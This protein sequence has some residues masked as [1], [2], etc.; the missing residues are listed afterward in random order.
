MRSIKYLIMIIFALLMINACNDDGGGGNGDVDNTIDSSYDLRLSIPNLE[1]G[2]LISHGGQ[3][4]IRAY[5]LKTTTDSNGNK[6]EVPVEDGTVIHFFVIATD[7][8]DQKNS[9]NNSGTIESVKTTLDGYADAVYQ[10]ENNSGNV[11]IYAATD[12]NMVY[13]ISDVYEENILTDT[14]SFE[15][16]SGTP[17][18]IFIDSITPETIGVAGS[19]ISNISIINF[20][21]NDSSGNPVPD[22][23]LVTFKISTAIGGGE[24]LSTTEAET[25][26]G[27]V[28][29][30]LTSGTVSGT[31]GI[32]AIYNDGNTDLL[33]EA[34][35][36]IVS[37]LPAA[38]QLGMAVEYHNMAGGRTFGL[39][40]K[41]TAYLGDRYGNVVP[42]GT[43]V[44]FM[45]EGGTIGTSDGFEP[46]TVF[47]VAEAV[48]QTSPPTTPDLG[49]VNGSTQSNPGLCRIVIYTPGNEG[50]YDINGNNVYDEGI[51]T[52]TVDMSEPYIDANDNNQYDSGEKYIDS[53]GSGSFTQADG[54]YQSNTIIWD[55]G[56]VLFSDDQAALDLTKNF[57]INRINGGSYPLTYYLGDVYG[58]ALVSGTTVKITTSGAF[59]KAEL[60]GDTDFVLP[61]SNGFGEWHTVGLLI[62]PQGTDDPDNGSLEVIVTVTPPSD[63]SAGENSSGPVTDTTGPL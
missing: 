57:N 56:N 13:N 38:E 51:D 24:K 20:S 59:G 36:T 63:D 22:Y 17:A 37:G 3:T 50:F 5:V 33:T 7:G 58:N 10:A 23:N 45:S 32:N 53:D 1:P 46:S 29:V 14:I 49:G 26:N 31:V 2:S 41:I 18:T 52:L 19:G 48:L 39:Q 8:I 55:S 27:K 25:Q 60:T 40:N 30:S 34:K 54:K 61:D 21:V 11:K 62:T 9:V 6:T 4:T 43:K 16:A 15:V 42:D 35:V 47:G 12:P 44:S 28:S